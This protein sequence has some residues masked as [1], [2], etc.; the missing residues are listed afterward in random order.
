MALVLRPELDE[1][2]QA[3][4]LT[5]YRQVIERHGGSV[6]ELNVW[7]KRRLAYDIK[8]QQEGIYVFVPFAAES[9]ANA[10]LD[11]LL[12][13]D[14]N[15]LRHLVVLRPRPNPP[16]PT[17]MPE[18]GPRAEG[19][20]SG[21]VPATERQSPGLPIRRSE[22]QAA[23]AAQAQAS[24]SESATPAAETESAPAPEPKAAPAPEP[25]VTAASEPEAA[26][27]SEPEAAPTPAEQEP[28]QE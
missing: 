13:I 1:E 23:Q 26:P 25:E 12:R 16:K 28:A 6:E 3:A 10:E 4:V 17:P 19:V 7:G 21:P 9:T 2:R 22:I 11:R 24:E 14:E 5:R 15:V 27:A 8:D 20:R 18:A